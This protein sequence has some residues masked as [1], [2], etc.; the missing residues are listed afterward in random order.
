P[1]TRESISW[2]EA[3]A[4]YGIPDLLKMDVE[5][6]E[7][8]FLQSEPFLNWLRRNRIVWI[9][10]VHQP[11]LRNLFPADMSVFEIDARHYLLNGPY[12]D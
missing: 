8:A 7:A 4:Q 6:Y 11:E 3:A 2:R 1:H 5:G 12:S 10:E 9:L